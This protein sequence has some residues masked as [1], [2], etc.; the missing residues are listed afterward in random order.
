MNRVGSG[1]LDTDSKG[2]D[3]YRIVVAAAV[4]APEES[5]VDAALD[6]RTE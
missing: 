2:E 6:R 3:H 4:K 5:G 1:S